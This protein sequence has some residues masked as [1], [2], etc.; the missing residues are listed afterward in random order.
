MR[1]HLRLVAAGANGRSRAGDAGKR[2]PVLTE[3]IMKLGFLIMTAAVGF[4][5]MTAALPVWAATSCEDLAKLTLTNATVTT[6]Q[7]V[8][9]G[10]FAPPGAD[11]V[12]D[13][14][15]FCRVALTLKPSS[16]SDIQLEV[17]MPTKDGNGKFQGVGNGGYAG[18][19]GF[20]D[21]GE[22][23]T[24]GYVAASTD[25]GHRA[26]PL[27]SRWALNHPEKTIDFGYRAIHES[28][29][30][31]KALIHAFYGNAPNHSYFSACSNGGRQALMEAQRYPEDYDGIIAGAPANWFTHLFSA[32]IINNQALLSDPA[33]YIPAA[34]LPA[35]DPAALA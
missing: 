24:H 7:S 2:Y 21:L 35:I 27:D 10:D 34:K 29:V 5:I 4:L 31:A 1:R 18:A 25:T 33:S 12:H 26:D 15:A 19:I 9:A 23:V 28:A 8:A 22:A 3:N 20:D 14:P 13:L 16:D 30:Q 11:A 6:A 17:W 32:A